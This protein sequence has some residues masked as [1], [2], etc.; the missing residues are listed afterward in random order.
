[1]HGWP[2]EVRGQDGNLPVPNRCQSWD[3]L[4]ANLRASLSLIYLWRQPI[5]L[6]LVINRGHRHEAQVFSARLADVTEH[7]EA[8]D[9]GRRGSEHEIGRHFFRRR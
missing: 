9:L 6:V 4:S 8:Q 2:S 3:A 5:A 7:L 1:M